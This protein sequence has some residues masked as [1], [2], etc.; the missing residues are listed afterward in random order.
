MLETFWQWPAARSG[1]WP[2]VTKKMGRADS[3]RGSVLQINP[4]MTGS[5]GVRVQV[6]LWALGKGLGKMKSSA[7]KRSL[8][9][10]LA[11][12]AVRGG[13]RDAWS[14]RLTLGTGMGRGAY[15]ALPCPEQGEYPR[16]AVPDP[17]GDVTDGFQ[18]CRAPPWACAAPWD[19]REL[20]PS[21]GRGQESLPWPGTESLCLWTKLSA[22]LLYRKG[23]SALIA[24]LT[25]LS[26]NLKLFCIA[27]SCS[28]ILYM[29]IRIL[30]WFL[31]RF[32]AASG[33]VCWRGQLLY[34]EKTS[35]Q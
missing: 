21:L 11:S 26:L 17:G 20:L 33:K 30:V 9:F 23:Q 32:K 27:L 25:P 8:G 4:E 18:T 7:A 35:L 29:K 2:T 34:N 31:E 5:T 19:K 6:L 14:V 3:E 13:G 1:V 16:A 12:S 15:R 22:G 10:C 24:S 28:Q